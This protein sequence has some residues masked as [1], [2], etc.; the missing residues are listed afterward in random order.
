MDR[1]V[2]ATVHPG[3]AAVARPCRIAAARR[4]CRPRTACRACTRT[5]KR[6]QRGKARIRVARAVNLRRA[7]E[8]TIESIV[9]KAIAVVVTAVADLDGRRTAHAARVDY[10]FRAAQGVGAVT[11]VGPAHSAFSAWGATEHGTAPADVARTVCATDRVGPIALVGSACTTG[12][13][14][15]ADEG[16]ASATGVRPLIQINLPTRAVAVR[17]SIRRGTLG[18][19]SPTR[20]SVHS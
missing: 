11:F 9:R 16:S 12:R 2:D 15:L 3:F 6:A 10:P 8:P 18:V 19:A 13:S 20:A 7:A 1:D 14:R 5:L 17:N 4:P